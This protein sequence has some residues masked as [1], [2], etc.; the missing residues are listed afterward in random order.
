M[1]KGSTLKYLKRFHFSS[2]I[3]RDVL[4]WAKGAKTNYKP[5]KKIEIEKSKIFQT[6]LFGLKHLPRW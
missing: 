5:K 6:F 1:E 4:E 2:G 3:C